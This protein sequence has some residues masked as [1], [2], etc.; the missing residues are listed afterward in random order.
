MID[1]LPTV[2]PKSD[3]INADDLIGGP[4]TIKVTKVSLTEEKDQPFAINFEGDGRKPY[5]PC[6]SMRRVMI[7]IWG[8]DARKINSQISHVRLLLVRRG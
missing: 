8:A 7:R 6:K 1:L 5:K 3:Q 4:L 2:I